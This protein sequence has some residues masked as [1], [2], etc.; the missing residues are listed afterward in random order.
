MSTISY[1]NDIILN[2]NFDDVTF[3]VYV[4][5]RIMYNSNINFNFISSDIMSTILCGS[6]HMNKRT[7]KTYNDGIEKFIC[8]KYI[9]KF[10]RCPNII[11]VNTSNIDS[12]QNFYVKDEYTN[13]IKIMN[14]S[15]QKIRFSLLR[16]WM[17]LLTTIYAQTKAGCTTIENISNKLGYSPRTVIRYFKILEDLQILYVSRSNIFY[18]DTDNNNMK[19]VSNAYG[20]YCDK[21]EIDNFASNHNNAITSNKSR[22]SEK[23]DLRRSYARKYSFWINGKKEYSGS[24]LKNQE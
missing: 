5:L 7:R 12:I 3:A 22:L 15:P 24:E 23:S 6:P 9:T 18:A 4:C 14:N 10:E 20:R 21:T 8:S 2:S 13:V 1:S 17:K 19:R 11:I 16:F